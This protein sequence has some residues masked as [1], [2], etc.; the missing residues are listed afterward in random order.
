LSTGWQPQQSQL[1]LS[2]KFIPLIFSLFNSGGGEGAG[3]SY[4]LGQSV[5]FRPSSTA[6]ITGPS[7]SAFKFD[8]AERSE[9]IDQPGIYTFADGDNERTFAVN[10]REAESRTETM[11]DTDLE[12]F[13]VALG[14]QL[15]TAQ[16]EAKQRQL[17]DLELEGRQKLWQWLL[18][19]ALVLLALETWLGGL[20]SR[21][22]SQ[23]LPAGSET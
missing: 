15:T 20:I 2:T 3:D 22:R 4:T 11:S 7:G 8:K 9:A 19:A 10:L 12:R 13:G 17:R 14:N 21:G 18:V 16:G 6:T 23:P 5:D 1:A